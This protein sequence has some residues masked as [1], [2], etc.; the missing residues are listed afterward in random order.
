MCKESVKLY[1]KLRVQYQFLSFC[2][3]LLFLIISANLLLKFIEKFAGRIKISPLIIGATIIA[4]GTSLPETFVAI[5]SIS[6]NAADI[7]LG[8]VIGSNIVNICL[9]LGL[10]I[11]LFPVRIGTEKTQRNNLVMLF[12]STVFATLFFVP[13]HFRKILGIILISSY[14]LFLVIE[15]VW[16]KSGRRH[17]DKKALAKIS[18]NSGSA[19]AYFFGIAASLAGLLISS[20]FLV[21]SVIYFSG[22]FKISE[23]IIGLSVVALG[24]SLP[25]L[26]TT[27]ISGFS[28]DWKLLYGDLQGSNIFNVSIVGAVLF[29]SGK[30]NP[31]I[32]VYPLAI[33]SI[34]TISIIFLSRKFEGRTIPRIY[35]LLFIGVY[36]FYILKI[37]GAG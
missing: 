31:Q 29:L 3:S 4:V 33:F 14:I 9:V 21:S 12:T 16:G 19:F 34:A 27:L 8:D 23:E 25:E 5:S 30:I 10:G 13:I 1:T 11:L 24:T 17:E 26:A 15:T 35:G 22:I 20:H 36:A 28:K 2:L 32:M 7:S 18:T 6:Q 37:Y